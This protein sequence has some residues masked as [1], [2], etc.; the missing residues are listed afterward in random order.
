[1]RPVLSGTNHCQTERWGQGWERKVCFWMNNVTV[2][3]WLSHLCA[4]SGDLDGLSAPA[5]TDVIWVNAYNP[6]TT[7]FLSFLTPC[8]ARQRLLLWRCPTITQPFDLK[9]TSLESRAPSSS[10]RE[11][12]ILVF[13]DEV[14]QRAALWNKVPLHIFLNPVSASQL[15]WGRD[16]LRHRQQESSC[17]A[18]WQVTKGT[19]LQCSPKA[20]WLCS[21]L[22]FCICLPQASLRLA[23]PFESYI[24][25]VQKA[26]KP[27]GLSP[28]SLTIFLINLYQDQSQCEMIETVRVCVSLIFECP[29]P[30]SYKYLKWR[31]TL[32]LLIIELAV[33]KLNW[34]LVHRNEI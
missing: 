20:P 18:D 9:S 5:T 7:G 12:N 2:S 17:E 10:L 8:F 14:G 34:G 25:S 15:S 26:E 28:L 29:R 23:K 19:V 30:K 31:E 11:L 3:L 27:L 16:Y 1:M 24:N 6:E 33:A 21:R 22:L 4:G 32:L 13:G